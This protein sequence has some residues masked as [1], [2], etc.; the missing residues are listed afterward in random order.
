MIEPIRWG[1]DS[2]AIGLVATL[3]IGCH[4]RFLPMAT[5]DDFASWNRTPLGPDPQMALVALEHPACRGDLDV[6]VPLTIVVQD[7][8]NPTSAAFFL[9]APGQFGSCFFLS[10]VSAGGGSTDV[11]PVLRGAITVDENASTRYGTV[12]FVTFG[13]LVAPEVAAVLIDLAD[14]Q[15]MHASVQNGFWLAW[16]PGL[17]KAVRVTAADSSGAIVG[18]LEHVRDD[19]VAPGESQ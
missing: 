12:T 5:A 10:G 15:Q 18:V 8:R 4:G 1:R 14:G 19:W 3:L 17:T 9:T 2:T 13:G 16:W 6:A 11:I 7:R